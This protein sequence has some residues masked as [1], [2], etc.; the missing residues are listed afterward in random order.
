MLSFVPSTVSLNRIVSPSQ[1]CLRVSSKQAFVPVTWGSAFVAVSKLGLVFSTSTRSRSE[2]AKIRAAVD[3]TPSHV[4]T[5]VSVDELSMEPLYAVQRAAYT[6]GGHILDW[7]DLADR[8]AE[9]NIYGLEGSAYANLQTQLDGLCKPGKVD[10]VIQPANVMRTPKRLAVFD[11]DSTLIQHE[12]IDELAA[13]LGLQKQVADITRQA[14]EGHLN[15]VDALA[16]RV[17]LLDGLS[18]SALEAVKRRITFTPG[19]QDLVNALHGSGCITAVVSGGF[20]FLADHIRDLLGLDHAFANSLEAS[21]NGKLTGRTVGPIVDGQF[22]KDTLL[23]LA[24]DLNIPL[25][26]VLAVGDGSNDLP[27]LHTAG[28]GVAFNAKPIVQ[29]Q[30]KVRVNQPNLQN[31][32]YMLGF[33]DDKIDAL[34][35]EKRRVVN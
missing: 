17:A 19:A 22:K 21:E 35:S 24:N 14:M 25:E 26:A 33:S 20:D 29:N 16:K 23:S 9:A 6:F 10:I 30:I 13:E 12:T 31:V 2:Y 5:I 3:R 8:A 7:R 28:L 15:F 1:R 34:L 4:V 32:L 27:M 11:L 18:V